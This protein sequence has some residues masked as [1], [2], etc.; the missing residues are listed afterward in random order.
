[1][2]LRQE[3]TKHQTKITNLQ[4]AQDGFM[5][6]HEG[7]RVWRYFK[8]YSITNPMVTNI[9]PQ[10]HH[11]PPNMV[12]KVENAIKEE[13]QEAGYDAQDFTIMPD[14]AFAYDL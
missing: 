4:H 9:E 8:D 2:A 11:A 7:D 13:L 6:C 1:M 5:S 3:L 12:E 10:I 14:G